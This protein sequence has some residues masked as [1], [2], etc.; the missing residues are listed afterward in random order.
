MLVKGPLYKVI[1]ISGI[2]SFMDEELDLIL[3]DL[4]DIEKD[5]MDQS[6]NS[7]FPIKPSNK[8]FNTLSNAVCVLITQ[9]SSQ[10]ILS[11]LKINLFMIQ[12]L[13]HYPSA[14]SMLF[15]LQVDVS[16]FF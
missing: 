10:A 9:D 15:S 2:K 1:F 11:N 7:S 13:N 14:S 12:L 4:D 8:P 16:V 3:C 5:L 6:M